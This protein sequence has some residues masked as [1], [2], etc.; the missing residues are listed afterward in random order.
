MLEALRWGVEYVRRFMKPVRI[1][2]ITRREVLPGEALSGDALR[3]FI[4]TRAW[5]HHASCTCRIGEAT[6]RD[7]VL[8][9]EFRVIGVPGGNLRV[10]DASVFPNIPGYFIVLPIYLIAEKAADVILQAHG[11]VTMPG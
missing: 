3:N 5:G 4:K 9:S 6:D 8:D 10:V 1:L 2:D 11:A 7:A